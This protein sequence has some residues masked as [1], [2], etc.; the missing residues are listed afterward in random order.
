MRVKRYTDDGYVTSELDDED[1]DIPAGQLI[2]LLYNKGVI[3]AEEV[4]EM[5]PLGLQ[6]AL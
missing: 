6:V 3:T 2:N 4:D 1:F 5:L